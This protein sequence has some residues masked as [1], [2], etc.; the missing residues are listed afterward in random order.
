[1][2]RRPPPRRRPRATPLEIPGGPEC[3]L[4]A[5]FMGSGKSTV[6]RI[7][8]RGLNWRFVDTDRLIR[9]E[10][11]S[12]IAEIFEREGEEYFR[13]LESEIAGRL[14]RM[15]QCVIATGGGFM[16]RAENREKAAAAGRIFLLVAT[17]EEIWHRVKAKRHRP[18][19]DVDDPEARIRELL[20]ERESAYGAIEDR[21]QTGRRPPEVIAREIREILIPP[22]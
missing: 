12:T 6:G 10:T 7:L 11:G 3:V 2:S 4:L 13:D 16:L 15:R 21:I 9:D 5:G 14:E 19:I 1:M 17:P 22:E 8:A 18:L 20:A